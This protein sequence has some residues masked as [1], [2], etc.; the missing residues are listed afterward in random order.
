MNRRRLKKAIKRISGLPLNKYLLLYLGNKVRQFGFEAVNSNHVAWPSNIMLELSAACNLTCTTCPREYEYGKNMD[1]GIM[2]MSLA[3]K[4]IDEAWPYLD[5]VGLTGMGETL[6]YNRVEEI[7]GYIKSKNKGIIISISTNAQVPDFKNRIAQ[8]VNKAD[9]I[10]ISADG[11]EEIYESIRRKAFFKKFDE[12]IKFASSLCRN[13]GTDLMINMVVTSENYHQMAD[14]IRYAAENGIA[15]LDFTQ[16]NLAAVTG[17]DTSY[18]EFYRSEE[19]LKAF[20]DM[21]VTSGR[22][23]EVEVT[24][25]SFDIRGLNGFRNCPF[26]WGHFYITWNGYLVPC[27]A[28]PFP[29]EMNFGNIENKS[30]I[31]LLNNTGFINFRKMWVEDKTPEFC[32]RCHFTSLH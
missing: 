3:K 17:F 9:T 6:L 30:L 27:C 7:T 28:K 15:Y 22:Y 14:M 19:F 12:N 31:E 13:S 23:P 21:E 1:Q 10:Q 11:L 26:P 20:S 16:F 2:D 32:N 25:K 24:A 5:S 4:I 8:L 29:K 18:Y